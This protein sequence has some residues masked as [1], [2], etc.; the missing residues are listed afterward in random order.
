MRILTTLAPLNMQGS[1]I[2]AMNAEGMT[3]DTYMG[4]P[5]NDAGMVRS[6]GT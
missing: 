1:V 3:H 5:P 6:V 2:V 4:K